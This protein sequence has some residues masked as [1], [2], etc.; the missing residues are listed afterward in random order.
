MRWTGSSGHSE[1]H[2]PLL[3]LNTM[4]P[5]SAPT[6]EAPISTAVATPLVFSSGLREATDRMKAAI[7]TTGAYSRYQSG[8][9]SPRVNLNRRGVWLEAASGQRLR[10]S[11]GAVN[12]KSGSEGMASFHHSSNP[13]SGFLRRQDARPIAA[14]TLSTRPTCHAQIGKRRGS[15]V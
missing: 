14:H 5:I 9:V 4:P 12:H 6:S 1:L 7:P 3:P 8:M 2:Q 15:W 11:P 13:F 10:H